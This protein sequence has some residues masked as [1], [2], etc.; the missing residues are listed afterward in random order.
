MTI[1]RR[2]CSRIQ[3]SAKHGL[4]LA[5][6]LL[7][8]SINVIAE[9][10]EIEQLAWLA[11]CWASVA[12]NSEA[13]STEQWTQPAG[14][15][16]LGVSRVV[17]DGRMV[18]FEYLRIV[19]GN[20]GGLIFIASPSGQATAEF[21]L[22]RLG[23]SEVVFENPQH[24]FPQRV[25]YRLV[26]DEQLLGRIEGTIDGQPRAVDFPMARVDCENKDS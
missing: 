8:L 26:D 13:G 2:G 4:A 17:R 14:G 19:A 24:D 1:F 22:A 21:A 16:M 18:A 25:I 6:S 5:A 3:R 9:E 20:H 7:F 11:G 15:S 12:Q 23:Q 10:A